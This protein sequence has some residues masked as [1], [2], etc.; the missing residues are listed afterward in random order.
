MPGNGMG[1]EEAQ[2]LFL[3]LQDSSCVQNRSHEVSLRNSI[4]SGKTRQVG[5]SNN[6]I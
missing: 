1:E 3:I 5:H 4:Y 2:T 6:R